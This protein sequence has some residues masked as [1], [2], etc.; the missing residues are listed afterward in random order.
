MRPVMC[1]DARLQSVHC[2]ATVSNILV[3]QAV[4]KGEK[5]VRV[6]VRH[7]RM[8]ERWELGGGLPNRDESRGLRLNLS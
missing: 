2:C 6:M 3:A 1:V 4:V 7:C 8:V 5:T